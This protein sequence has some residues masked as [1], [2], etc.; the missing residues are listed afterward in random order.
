MET[1]LRRYK[2]FVY[3]LFSE[4]FRTAENKGAEWAVSEEPGNPAS[5]FSEF[6]SP[7]NGDF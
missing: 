4:I 2:L 7:C 3:K 1:L 6:Q 5:I